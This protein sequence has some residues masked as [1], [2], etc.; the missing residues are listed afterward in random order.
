VAP[1]P[2]GVR[3]MSRSSA[4]LLSA[5]PACSAAGALPNGVSVWRQGDRPRASLG[6]ERASKTIVDNA[7]IGFS[8]I[9]PCFRTRA[10]AR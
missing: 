4:N 7:E 5:Y 3:S 8:V 9:S 2:F 6:G 10:R 1:R